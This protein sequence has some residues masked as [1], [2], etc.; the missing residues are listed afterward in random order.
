[1]FMPGVLFRL[2]NG[3]CRRVEELVPGDEMFG[4]GTVLTSTCTRGKDI[5][6]YNGVCVDGRQQVFEDNHFIMVKDSKQSLRRPDL[7]GKLVYGAKT[8]GDRLIDI[9]QIIFRASTDG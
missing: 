4:G 6:E 9:N 1:M 5:Y 8:S 7:D 2:T 3:Q